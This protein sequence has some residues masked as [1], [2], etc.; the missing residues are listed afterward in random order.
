[1]I[2]DAVRPVSRRAG[3]AR[4]LASTT[5]IWALSVCGWPV[6]IESS[7]RSSGLLPL[8]VTLGQ[9]AQAPAES[10]CWRLRITRQP[11]LDRPALRA[12]QPQLQASPTPIQDQISRGCRRLMSAVQARAQRRES[13]NRHNEL[14]GSHCR[15]DEGSNVAVVR[16]LDR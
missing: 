10:S 7:K 4:L 11:N 9:A 2:F 12:A 13:V 6:T 15:L 14:L 5:V 1:M 8:G 16:A 3:E